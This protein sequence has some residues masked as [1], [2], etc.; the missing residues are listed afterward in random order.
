MH[1]KQLVS[2]RAVTAVVVVAAAAAL[3]LAY[4][5]TYGSNNQLTY[6]LGPL[7]RAHPELY[8]RDWLVATTTAYHPVFAWLAAPMYTLDPGGI[9]AFAIAQLVVMVATFALLYRLIAAL[10]TGARLPMFLLLVGLLALGGG[11]AMAGSYLFAGYL[12]PSSLAT[13]GWLAAL[14]AWL[15]DRPL[16]AGVWLALAGACHINFLVLGIGLFAAVELASRRVDLR[17]LAAVL[18][19]S[20]VVLAAFS[21]VMLASAG[22]HD[23]DLALRILVK[24]HAPG[25]YDPPRFRRWLPPLLAWLVVAWAAL[26]VARASGQPAVDRLWRFAAAATA[27]CVAATAIVSI[28]PWLGFT[29]LYVWRIAP[30]AQLASQLVA[31]TA[32]LAP[33]AASAATNSARRTLAAVIGAAVVIFEALHLT[34]DHL[35]TAA[36]GIVAAVALAA[37]W[38]RL[39]TPALV[40]AIATCGIA[41]ATQRDTLVDSPLFDPKCVGDD[42][43]LIDW[44]KTKTPVDAV[45]LVP[46]YMDW[47][48]LLGERA[49]VADTK[50]PPLYPDELVEWYRRLCAMVDAP[51]MATHEAVEARW[52]TLTA[53]P[54]L[55]AARR[56]AVDYVLLY[57]QRSPA[58][59]AQPVAFENAGYVVY[60]VR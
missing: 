3:A 34:G 54:L 14:L 56:F 51:D 18:G 52:D 23:P 59:L 33:A 16:A 6:L 44:V 30:F 36:L 46:P 29:R 24:F 43:V 45:F 17:R 28:P 19:P 47:F 35:Y 26:P 37:R 49:V 15:R 5:K 4:G 60:R 32:A 31:I 57:K 53:D 12:Q 21:P 55:A 27:V 48:R 58:R 39:R 11:H 42:C 2:R 20:L 1:A 13:L 50:S 9:V 40:L 25:H 38:L 7:R 41:L 22:A 10:A 8:R